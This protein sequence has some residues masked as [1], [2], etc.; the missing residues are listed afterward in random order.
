MKVLLPWTTGRLR[1]NLVPTAKLQRQ[2]VRSKRHVL[3]PGQRKEITAKLIPEN[4]GQVIKL[5]TKEKTEQPP[6]F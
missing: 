6:M 2:V 4:P 3:V 5:K 1:L